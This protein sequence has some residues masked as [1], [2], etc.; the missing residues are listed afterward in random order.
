[1]KYSDEDAVTFGAEYFYDRSGYE[2]ARIYPVLLGVA[3]LAA[4]SRLDLRPR[5]R[6]RSPASRTRSP[7]STS[8]ATTRAPSRRCPGP[9]RW[10]DTSFTLSALGNL[11]DKSFVARLDHSVLALTYL[12]VE[13]YVAGHLGSRQGEFRLGFD[14]PPQDV[15]GGLTPGVRDRARWSSRPGSRCASRCSGAPTEAAPHLRA[16]A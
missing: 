12:R 4:A 1:M 15:G 3:A 11:S 10:N 9:G 5:S 16:P 6:I 7:P 13:T 8:G 14:I 2:S